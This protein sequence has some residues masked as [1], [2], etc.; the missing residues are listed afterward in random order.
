MKGNQKR[1]KYVDVNAFID[2][3][4]EASDEELTAVFNCCWRSFNHL[5][6]EGQRCGNDGVNLFA[7]I[8]EAAFD[9]IWSRSDSKKE[10]EAL[11]VSLTPDD[12]KTL[13]GILNGDKKEFVWL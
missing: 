12:M 1:S 3:L 11:M 13:R 7:M 10:H 4:P 5:P 2:A 9:V 8:K 6:D